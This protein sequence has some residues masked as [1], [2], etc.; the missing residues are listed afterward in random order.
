MAF[1]Y[2]IG[3]E[4]LRD[5]EVCFATRRSKLYRSSFRAPVRAFHAGRRQQAPRLAHLC[6]FRTS[7]SCDILGTRASCRQSKGGHAVGNEKSLRYPA[8]CPLSHDPRAVGPDSLLRLFHIGKHDLD[9]RP[10]HHVAR[11]PR[12][13]PGSAPP[14][15]LDNRRM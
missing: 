11:T 2:L 7:A 12:H 3:R 14:Y 13:P 9:I 5:L 15:P 6:G 1:A 10:I 8:S 4:S